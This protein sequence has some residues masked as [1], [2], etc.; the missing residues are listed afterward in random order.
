MVVEVEP[1]GREVPAG[2]EWRGLRASDVERPRPGLGPC[3]GAVDWL[4]EREHGWSA[5]R[6]AWSR[7][8]WVA[9]AG[10]WMVDRMR[11]AGYGDPEPPRLHHL[12]GLSA[13][14]AS[15]AAGG[16]AYLKCS[17]GYFRHEA[18][19]TA[20][21]ARRVPRPAPGGAGRRA[22]RGVVAHARAP[23]ARARRASG[24]RVGGRAARPGGA[25][26]P[27]ARAGRRSSWPSAHDR[28]RSPAL[29]QWVEQTVGA[30]D[31]HGPPRAGTTAGP[32]C[33]RSRT[34]VDACVRL[35]ALGPAPSLVHGDFHPVERGGGGRPGPR[36][37]TGPTARS[38]TRSSTWSTY[39]M[40]AKDDDRASAA[41]GRLP[42][43][44]DRPARCSRP[45]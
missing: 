13:V 27:V 35:D 20:A 19:L 34:L 15:S 42:R 3:L 24:G 16:T 39:V 17:P 44:L 11:E 9:V 45:G 6:P 32:G 7:P 36:S 18:V 28:A 21:L 29:A 10:A 26:A 41:H 23:D 12:W 33:G 31:L 30:D 14:L 4:D 43:A 25:A 8:G 38:R 22:R 5:L 1:L 2:M 37:S 40:R